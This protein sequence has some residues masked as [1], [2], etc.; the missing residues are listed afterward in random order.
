MR[1]VLVFVFFFPISLYPQSISDDFSDGDFTH[2]PHWAGDSAS[3]I[4]NASRQLQLHE[5]G[6][7]QSALIL[8]LP[9]TRLNNNEWRFYI[10]ENF[11]P[12][13]NNFSRVYLISDK[14]NLKDSLH[15][16]FLQFGEAG[17]N[18][19][20]ELFRQQG[21]QTSS[22]CRGRNGSIASSFIFSVKVLRDSLGNWKVYTDPAG[23]TNYQ[24]DSQGQ[25]ILIQSGTC[26]GLLATYTLTDASK[27]YWDDFYIG[28]L[29]VDRTPPLLLSLQVTGNHNLDVQFNQELDTGSAETQNNYKAGFFLGHPAQARADSISKGL[30]HLVF[31]GT[32]SKD[33]VYTLQVTSVK[34]RLGIPVKDS[35]LNFGIFRADN[36]DVLINEIMAKPTPAVGLPPF[37]YIELYNKRHFPLNLDNWKLHIG[38]KEHLLSGVVIEADSFVVLCSLAAAAVFDSTLPVFGVSG[39]PALNN[40]AEEICLKNDS[41]RVISDVRYND[42]W[43]KD[44][45][46]KGGGWSLEQIDPGNP[47]GGMENW[48]ASRNSVGGSPGRKNSVNAY[49]PDN[50]PP[51]LLRVGIITTASICLTFDEAMDSISLLDK[52][53]YQLDTSLQIQDVRPV[54][55]DYSQVIINF[56]PLLERRRIYTIRL[57]SGLKDCAGNTLGPEGGARFALPDSVGTSDIIFNEILPDPKSGGVKYIELYN[58]SDK[59]AD[60]KALHLANGDSLTGLLSDEKI[61]SAESYLLFP[62]SFVLLSPSAASVGKQY[63]CP[64]P[65]NMLDLPSLPK[66]DIGGGTLLLV[67]SGGLVIDRLQ[68]T[69]AWQFPLLANTKGVSLERI[70]YELITQ[71]ATNW[72]SASETS[73]FGT[74]GYRNS[75]YMKQVSGAGLSFSNDLFSPDEDGYQDVLQINYQL[76][77]PD[78]VGTL[79]VFD[80]QGRS[81]RS[82]MRNS[83]LGAAGSLIWDGLTENHEKARVGIYVICLEVFDATGKI[84]VFRKACVVAAKL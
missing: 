47:C 54:G 12:S 3:F 35:S 21:T 68:Y 4:V 70:D 20:V 57:A 69:A 5:S 72:H 13:A 56:R 26:F 31:A 77:K 32:I 39:F 17:S 75:E 14:Q 28:P 16:Y 7:G 66:M 43:Y 34:N 9:Y 23:G 64:S 51:E 30:I 33:T 46:K 1:L 8:P 49:N 45:I 67:S 81:I 37:E 74:P 25:D 50:K 18:D 40:T 79:T 29:F 63:Y 24:I 59:I 48:Q 27:F 73:G 22:V 60:L 82:L 58:R 2:N 15:G 11:S 36:Y 41:G 42:S 52:N 83:L 38:K 62:G 55:L 76:N 71:D 19:A 61:I 6:P 44:N 10:R 65:E 53:L 78:Y 84:D 80:A